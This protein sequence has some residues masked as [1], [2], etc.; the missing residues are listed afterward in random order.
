MWEWGIIEKRPSPWGS[1][2]TIVP[3]KN[4][5]PRFRVDY[6]HTLNRHIVR[7][8]WPLPN[9][10]TCLDSVGT[11]AF[12]SVADI[13][14]AF[15]QLPVAEDHIER[16]AFVT[17]TGNYCFHRMLSGVCNAPWLFQHIMSMTLGH[18]GPESG[19]L[20]YMDGINVVN[21]TFETHLASLEQLLTALQA[22]GLTLKTVKTSIR[23]EKDRI[24]RPRHFRERCFSQYRPHQSNI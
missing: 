1:P 19:I 15:W 2:I 9:L 7:K 3:K 14:S 5:S 8:S 23:S 21:P 18:L 16:T 13:K 24:S 12:I 6:R 10:E 17:P 11:A 22:A 4:D 20:S